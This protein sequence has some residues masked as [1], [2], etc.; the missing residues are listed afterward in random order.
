[1]S[2]IKLTA[3]TLLL[4]SLLSGC[5]SV[6][7]RNK[8]PGLNLSSQEISFLEEHKKEIGTLITKLDKHIQKLDKCE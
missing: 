5:V 8:C 7:V 6:Q 3:V 4:T 1:M 2:G